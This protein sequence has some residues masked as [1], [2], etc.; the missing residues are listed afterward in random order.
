[1]EGSTKWNRHISRENVKEFYKF[2]NFCETRERSAMGKKKGVEK[3]EDE[4]EEVQEKSSPRESTQGDRGVDSDISTSPGSVVSTGKEK[5]KGAGITGGTGAQGNQ[6]S[7]KTLERSKASNRSK[8]TPS[9]SPASSAASSYAEMVSGSGK[10]EK[11]GR[12][13]SGSEKKS[14]KS[15]S[16]AEDTLARRL[17]FDSTEKGS[18]GGKKRP[19]TNRSPPSGGT[20]KAKKTKGGDGLASQSESE[21]RAMREIMR[22]LPPFVEKAN[23]S[24]ALEMWLQRAEHLADLSGVDMNRKTFMVGLMSRMGSGTKAAF[25]VSSLDIKTSQ[26]CENYKVFKAYLLDIA[27]EGRG[28]PLSKWKRL[29]GIRL[30]NCAH[31]QEYTYK[32]LWAVDQ[33][34]ASGAFPAEAL[35][36][37]FMASLPEELQNLMLEKGAEL[38]G[39]EQGFAELKRLL[40]LKYP[41]HVNTSLSQLFGGGGGHLQRPVGAVFRGQNTN[42]GTIHCFQCK[43]IGHI[44]RNCT[45]SRPATAGGGWYAGKQDAQWPRGPPHGGARVPYR[46]Q[47][48]TGGQS[49][50][51]PW[52]T[53]GYASRGDSG[54]SRQYPRGSPPRGQGGRSNYNGGGGQQQGPAGRQ[55]ERGPGQG[56]LSMRRAEQNY[57]GPLD[58]DRDEGSRARNDDYGH[59]QSREEQRGAGGHRGDEHDSQRRDDWGANYD[60]FGPDDRRQ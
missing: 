45:S 48:R 11:S 16:Y 33:F 4:Q 36:G 43:G 26:F 53:V 38:T 31:F 19:G 57:Y 52:T 46:S 40:D 41:S 60:M 35:V 55:G 27:G 21:E 14:E 34:K 17:E 54:G 25:A 56:Q 50:D 2:M 23:D 42:G 37:A 24:V 3:E 44:A 58:R 29:I 6:M 49:T 12:G 51:G 10:T 9:H 20:N 15:V 39:L 8:E 32:F 28:A 59:D 22:N 30:V 1:M 47:E 7:G 18:I 13:R 5:G